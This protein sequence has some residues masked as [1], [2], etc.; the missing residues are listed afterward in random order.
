MTSPLNQFYTERGSIA[1]KWTWLRS[2]VIDIERRIRRCEETYKAVRGKKMPIHL[3]KQRHTVEN[4]VLVSVANKSASDLL[5]DT[6]NV[7]NNRKIHPD[8]SSDIMASPITPKK[9]NSGIPLLTEKD[10]TNLLLNAQKCSIQHDSDH[11]NSCTAART[12]CVQQWRKRKLFNLTQVQR[13]SKS[14]VCTCGDLCTPCVLCKRISPNL[15]RML[16]QQDL[17]DRVSLIDL[18]FH[19]V[20]SFEA[21]KEMCQFGFFVTMYI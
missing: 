1:S 15:P 6:L 12:R 18:S 2:Q 19:P 4:N 14:M 21:G 17:R 7:S 20:L 16:Q 9:D 3:E 5:A 13:P 10:K 11:V 8:L